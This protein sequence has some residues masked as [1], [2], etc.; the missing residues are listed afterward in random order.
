[1]NE[2][3][4]IGMIGVFVCLAIL[5]PTLHVQAAQGD[6]PDQQP[7]EK[8]GV[9]LG[10]FLSTLDT[11]FRIGSGVG[12]D[13]DVEEALDLDTSDTTFRAEALWRFTDN[14][15]QRL[16]FSWFSLKGTAP[17]R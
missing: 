1:M 3:L 17:G 11:S 15:R 10:A 12:L 4:K 6:N 9:N 14:R 2:R 7:W 5:W 13:I 8:F 16:D